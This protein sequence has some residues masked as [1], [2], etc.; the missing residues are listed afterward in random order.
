MDLR[1]P[2]APYSVV[3]P[4]YNAARTLERMLAAI[5]ELRPQ[6]TLYGGCFFVRRA[7]YLAVGGFDESFGRAPC[8]DG[9]VLP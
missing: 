2:L 5:R 7:A 6:P 4:V 3:V 1:S 8:E 9:R